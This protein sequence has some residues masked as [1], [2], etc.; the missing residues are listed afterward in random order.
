MFGAGPH[1][2]GV[3]MTVRR[4]VNGLVVVKSIIP[5]GQAEKVGVINGSLL[6][7][8]AKKS[9]ASL[10]IANSDQLAE[11]VKSQS[12]PMVLSFKSPNGS[13]QVSPAIAL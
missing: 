3:E 8:V 9:L 2:F 5:N 1:G 10:Q 12:R 7:A 4:G 13:A 11:C 6:V